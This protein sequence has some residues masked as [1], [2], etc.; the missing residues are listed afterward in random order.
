MW[1]IHKIKNFYLK[2]FLNTGAV[3]I[4]DIIGSLVASMAALLLVS[5]FM[6]N[7]E[8]IPQKILLWLGLSLISSAIYFIICRAYINIIRYSNLL[9]FGILSMDI[10]G[11]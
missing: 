9:E 6:S 10:L 7:F 3:F 2:R 11:K 5:E 8:F 1:D 4:V